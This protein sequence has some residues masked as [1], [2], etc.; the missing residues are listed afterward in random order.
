M[1]QEFLETE[2][3]VPSAVCPVCLSSFNNEV[4][5]VC[6]SNCDH[7]IHQPCF[8]SY[9]NYSEI[10]I[11][12]ELNEWPEDMKSKVDQVE[13]VNIK[14]ICLTCFHSSL[15]TFLVHH[16][17]ILLYILYIFILYP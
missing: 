4:G 12:R 9:V 6:T 14:T 16:N 10:E 2:Q 17:F 3:N 8:A 11:E 5:S 7:Y 13:G 15:I 1:I